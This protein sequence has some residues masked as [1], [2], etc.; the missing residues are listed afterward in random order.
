MYSAVLF[1]K[2]QA[3]T[4]SALSLLQNPVQ[5]TLKFSF[6]SGINA[7][8]QVTVYNTLG[9]KVYQTSFAAQK[10][11]NTIAMTLDGQIKGG[12]YVLEVMNATNR[13]SAKFLKN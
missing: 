5:S 2:K 10:G 8:T 7:A 12:T 1:I 3:A 4:T 11:T 13:N 6:Q 9:V